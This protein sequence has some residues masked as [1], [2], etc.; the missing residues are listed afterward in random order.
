MFGEQH[1]LYDSD[2]AL[3]YLSDLRASD[4]TIQMFRGVSS[5][6]LCLAFCLMATP[7]FISF[8]TTSTALA[9]SSAGRPFSRFP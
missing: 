7:K 6:R 4:V 8:A 9:A 5:Y 3:P 2:E 1:G